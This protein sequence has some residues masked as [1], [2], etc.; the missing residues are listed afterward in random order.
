MELNEHDIQLIERY[1]Q[2]ELKGNDLLAFEQQMA[3]DALFSSEVSAYRNLYNGIALHGRDELR[4]QLSVVENSM[5]DANELK[6]YTPTKNGTSDSF[7]TAFVWSLIPIV[8]SVTG[9]LYWL[10]IDSNTKEKIIIT[11]PIDS[12]ETVT[13]D[14]VVLDTLEAAIVGPTDSVTDLEV[15]EIEG[16]E[17]PAIV[18]EV[19]ENEVTE[20]ILEKDVIIE[21]GALSIDTLI[22]SEE[23]EQ[24]ETSIV[25]KPVSVSI[26]EENKTGSNE[27]PRDSTN[28]DTDFEM[29]DVIIKDKITE[30]S[31]DSVNFE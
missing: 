30:F 20:V 9:L 7:D 15:E 8:L 31:Q 13:I 6:G 5:L 23:I 3:R 28:Y 1:L 25:E 16:V 29:E 24:T 26:D 2:G 17:K 10:Q 22:S 4:K 21:E 12:V 27:L 18:P 11:P 14:S 19:E